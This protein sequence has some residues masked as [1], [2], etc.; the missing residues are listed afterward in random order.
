[1]KSNL[2]SKSETAKLVKTISEKLGVVLP[3]NKNL[4][5]HQITDDA[6]LITGT[7]VKILKIN[8]E[9]LP[10]LSETEMLKKIPSVTVDAGATKP[11]CKGANVMRPG[12]KSFSE[13]ENG[14]MVGVIEESRRV[15]L[16]VGKAAVSSAELESMERGEV[17]KNIHH[18]SDRF[19]EIGRTVRD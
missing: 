13:F 10:F 12:I 4:K 7:G 3:K 11:M 15:F 8:G 19:W 2:I 16:A 5:V 17:L 1:L 9:Y 18:I 6:Q 14:S